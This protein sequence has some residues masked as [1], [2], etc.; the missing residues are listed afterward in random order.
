MALL[1]V[2]R[3]SSVEESEDLATDVVVS[4]LNVVHDA[5]VGGEDD[6]AELSGGQNLV[7]ELLEVLELEVESGGDHAALVKSSVE[8]DDDLAVSG[9]IDHL[10]CVDVT[11][12]LHHAQELNDHLGDWS[13]HNLEQE[14]VKNLSKRSRGP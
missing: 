7:D 4:G 13:D 1:L 11:V 3:G 10:E 6:V 8:V 9:I 5:L 14:M 12:L 2:N